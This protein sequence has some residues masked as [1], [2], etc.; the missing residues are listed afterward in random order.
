MINQNN[1]SEIE[2]D[3]QEL[4]AHLENIHLDVKAPKHL[5]KKILA[6]TEAVTKNE[7]ARSLIWREL[8]GRLPS[9]KI[10][11][12]SLTWK[13]FL[14]SALAL[15][16]VFIVIGQWPQITKLSVSRDGMATIDSKSDSSTDAEA[17][18]II[19]DLF[20]GDSGDSAISKTESNDI[21][22][23]TSENRELVSI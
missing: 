19:Q 15:T 5:L 20:D 23:I 13:I 17:D 11:K 8:K 7:P 16:M 4:C 9:F 22:L 12:R 10:F 1:N 18:E 2:N 14:P 21:N 3:F 6:S